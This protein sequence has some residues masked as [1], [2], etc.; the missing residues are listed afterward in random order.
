MDS[1]IL[2]NR[3]NPTSNSLRKQ[4]ST[5]KNLRLTT[6]VL[7]KTAGKIFLK[8][9]V[10]EMFGLKIVVKESINTHEFH[11][12]QDSIWAFSLNDVVFR[13]AS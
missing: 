8:Y 4:T 10:A 12:H 9:F 7:P 5:K 3:E 11:I 1:V 6:Y 2:K 13:L